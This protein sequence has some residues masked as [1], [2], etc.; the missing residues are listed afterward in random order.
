MAKLRVIGILLLIIC[1]TIACNSHGGDAQGLDMMSNFPPEE[2][3]AK[4]Q[5]FHAK[6]AELPTS[7][8]VRLFSRTDMEL[9]ES[10]LGGRDFRII[11]AAMGALEKRYGDDVMDSLTPEDRQ[12]LRESLRRHVSQDRYLGSSPLWLF[13]ARYDGEYVARLLDENPK[14]LKYDLNRSIRCLVLAVNSDRAWSLLKREAT[15]MP[16]YRLC[17]LM[18]AIGDTKLTVASDFVFKKTR[19]WRWLVRLS[20]LYALDRLDDPRA[21]DALEASLGD[22]QRSDP[23]FWTL[24]VP[25]YR[26]GRRRLSWFI[27]QEVITAIAARRIP[28]AAGTLEKILNNRSEG[29]SNARSSAGRALLRLDP[30]QG[31]AV[32]RKLLADRNVVEQ[33]VGINMAYWIWVVEGV[34]EEQARL[35]EA[36]LRRLKDESPDEGVRKLA[37]QV[38]RSKETRR[39]KP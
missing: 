18:G 20:A 33:E 19:D 13:A 8:L 25:V 12:F 29:L 34:P 30:Q 17:A 27:R 5:D 24:L 7:T 2:L 15:W 22:I 11:G 32:I 4:P 37:L 9:E 23:G 26:I 31:C 39:R 16:E 10:L 3:Y 28:G 35:I 6:L 36:E 1:S 38:L 21:D 14:W